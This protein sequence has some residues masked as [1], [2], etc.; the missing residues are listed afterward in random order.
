MGRRSELHGLVRNLRQY[1]EWQAV[2]LTG[3]VP[4]EPSERADFA[5]RKKRRERAR[6][7]AA[8]NPEPTPAS[9]PA[10]KPAGRSPAET[11]ARK[12][13]G[14]RK[15]D[16]PRKESGP[17]LWRKDAGFS[18]GPRRTFGSKKKARPPSEKSQPAPK[19]PAARTDSGG[20]MTLPGIRAELGDCTRCDLCETRTNIVFGVGNPEARLM[21]IGEA[22]GYNEDKQGEPFVGKAGALL[23]KMIG[24]MT[25]SRG[26]V[27]IANVI[28]CRPPN[29]RDPSPAEVATC[30]PFLEKQVAAIQPDVIVAL[31]KF[32][33]N[34]LTGNDG[35]L[36][37]IRGRWHE[38][39]GV[40]VMPTYHP[41]YLLRSPNQKGKTW[42]D[43]K[44]VMARLELD[45]PEKY[46]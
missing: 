10:A 20:P 6:L 2:P 15:Q 27:Y 8:L 41:A 45:I 22:P 42:D 25:L 9:A 43:L 24:A 17:G 37:R 35:S 4:A 31:G 1:L 13:P 12:P 19:Q 21:F 11:P 23:D 33:S 16:K 5:E 18:D 32:A 39:R 40:P 36:G 26:E 44:K 28:K 14:G 38:Y 3:A 34:M 7:D 29:N 30:S 46:R